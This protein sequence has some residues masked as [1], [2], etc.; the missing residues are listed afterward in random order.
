VVEEA[1]F[2]EIVGTCAP[3]L[4]E[5]PRTAPA[6]STAV[7]RSPSSVKNGGGLW[8]YSSPGSGEPINSSS[9]T[10]AELPRTCSSI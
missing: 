5:T 8:A 1:G 9:T 6:S 4:V 10:L 7:R 3:D 2:V